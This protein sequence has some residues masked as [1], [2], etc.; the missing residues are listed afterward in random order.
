MC[1]GPSPSV[2]RDKCAGMSYGHHGTGIERGVQIIE[3]A[4]RF[5]PSRPDGGRAG[6]LMLELWRSDWERTRKVMEVSGV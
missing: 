4:F 3:G 5:R 6:V 1:R 2:T